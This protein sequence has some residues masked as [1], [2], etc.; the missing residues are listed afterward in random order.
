MAT[1]TKPGIEP[2][3]ISLLETL[4]RRL[5]WLSSW[6]IHNA[7]NVRESRDNLK[8]GGHQASCAS[9]SSIMTALYF[10]ALGPNDKVAVKPHAGPVLHAIHYLL[11]SQSRE[12]LE[13][14]RGFG[15]AQ[16]YPSRTKDHIPVDFSTGS[17]GLGVAVTAFASLVQDYMVAHGA[18]APEK[19]GRMVA[20]MGD[21][22]LDEGNIYE[23]LIE[24]YKHDVRN[25][26]WIVDYNRQSLDHTTADRMF[27]R[28]DDIFR[29]CGWRVV[30][31]KYGKLMEAAF[32]EPGGE[33]LREWIDTTSNAEYA[34]LTYQ[35]GEQW[36]ARLTRDIGEQPGVADLL[37]SRD[38]EA[39]ARLMTNL[40][41]HCMESLTEAFDAADDDTPTLF[42][43][44]TIKGYGLPFAGHKDNHAGLMNTSQIEALRDQQGIAAGSE[45]EPY[46]GIGDNIE[47][48]LRDLVEGTQ[49][50]REKAQVQAPTFDVPAIAAPEGSEQAT[51]TAFGKILLD[52]A[53]GGSPLADRI[54]TTSPDVTVSTNLGAWVNQRGL[55]RRQ[56]MEDVFR[57]AR[58]PS[59]QK[60]EGD[61]AGQHLELGIAENN[62]FLALAA[63]GLSG[64]L[65]GERLLPIGTVYDPFIARGLDALNY[66]CY[67]D[68]RFMLVATPA[69]VTLGPEGG[70]HQSINPPLIAMGQPGLRHYEPAFVDELAL[71]M[72]E[73]F[74]LMQA[75][76]GESVYFRLTTRSIPQIDRTHD[77]WREGAKKGAYWL[78]EPGEAAEAAIVT[79]GAITPEAIAACDAM[80]DDLPG[81]GLLVVTSPDLLHR[82]WS[83]RMARDDARASHIENLLSQLP[84]GAQ[85]VTM[86][87]GSPGALSWLG[88]VDG[89]R[90]SPLGVDRFGQTGDLVDLYREYRLD[91][92]AVIAAMAKLFAA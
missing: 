28:F 92:D 52:L 60:W 15:G 12:Q 13:A 76:D 67:Q 24:G 56:Q 86:L 79:M 75:P 5:R 41:G 25:C 77:A 63:M 1:K 38:E 4:D 21:A 43:A 16:S 30:T 10:H 82:E 3:R 61:T 8:V 29:T 72:E 47:S 54:T 80:A 6:T 31:L 32:E 78:R 14:F 85:L 91:P 19:T 88:S 35:G 51:Q 62:L 18:L 11:G 7:N 23:C 36:R 69:G 46:A 22:E 39:L 71:L 45:W 58:I 37:E 53:K 74:A 66:A 44:Y 83:A 33:A 57:K 40:G 73:A 49:I 90:V 59:A 50:A 65:F 89:R 81:L 2:D 84:A 42:I 27:R 87:D 55:F 9:I 20:L 48:A 64:A 70:A 17:V 68:A 26:W 34:A